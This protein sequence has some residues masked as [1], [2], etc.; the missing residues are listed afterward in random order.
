MNISEYC[1][2]LLEDIPFSENRPL[3]YNKSVL[4]GKSANEYKDRFEEIYKLSVNNPLM[5]AIIGKPGTGKTQFLWNLDYRSKNKEIDAIVV[6]ID[7]KDVTLTHEDIIKRIYNEMRLRDD[8]TFNNSDSNKHEMVKKIN[9]SISSLRKTGKKNC[10]LIV[11]VDEV[12]EHL[13]QRESIEG[14]DKKDYAIDLLGS[15]RLLLDEIDRLSVLFTMTEDVWSS[16]IQK[17]LIEDQTL[18]RRFLVSNGVDG[19]ILQ[20][21]HFSEREAQEMVSKFLYNWRNKNNIENKEPEVN[22]MDIYPFS[23]ESIKIIWKV[24]PMP[25]DFSFICSRIILEKCLSKPRNEKDF[26]ISKKN[27]AYVIR[28]L[29]DDLSEN[30]ELYEEI[31][32][33]LEGEEIE[34]ELDERVSEIDNTQAIINFLRLLDLENV[35]E[36]DGLDVII[37]INERKIGIIIIEGSTIRQNDAKKLALALKEQWVDVG[38]FLCISDEIPIFIHK[39]RWKGD[40]S[41]SIV[42]ASKLFLFNQ[43]DYKS[44]ISAKNVSTQDMSRIRSLFEV[45]DKNIRKYTRYININLSLNKYINSIANLE[46]IKLREKLL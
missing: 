32:F 14:K 2:K 26:I 46:L 37:E 40:N 22:R 23:K 7:L 43:F 30:Q 39:P 8:V 6:V 15:F 27:A 25:G 45:H 9:E 24:A 13:R 19:L 10:G 17:C 42:E 21:E 11:A 31:E 3:L 33:I 28:R 18:K 36:D 4:I 5:T 34:R 38:L 1:K 29:K 20:L 12:D 41:K 16:V 44:V 35:R